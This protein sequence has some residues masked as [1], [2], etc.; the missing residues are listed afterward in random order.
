M[1]EGRIK[2]IVCT[3]AAA[4]AAITVTGIQYGDKIISVTDLST[5]QA[6][7][8]LQYTVATAGGTISN[9]AGGASTSGHLVLVMWYQHF[10]YR[11]PITE[12]ASTVDASLRN[13]AAGRFGTP[14]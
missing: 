8:T 11:D 14:F 1:N 4:G 12:E 5:A 13:T 2:Q 9:T 7:I 10:Q 3:G 6:D